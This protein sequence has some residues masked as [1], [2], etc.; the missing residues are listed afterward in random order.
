MSSLQNASLA[1]SPWFLGLIFI[2]ALVL[3]G[4]GTLLWT[5]AVAL[6]G[7]GLFLV[8]APPRKGPGP[9]ADLAVLGILF[10]ILLGFI[11]LTGSFR[12]SWWIE[13]AKSLGIEL[14][15]SVTLQPY[16]SLEALI[17]LLAGLAWLYSAVSWEIGHRMRK[18]LLWAFVISITLLSVGVIAGTLLQM[19][20]PFAKS[21]HNFSYFP[22]RNQTSSLLA[23]GGVVSFGLTM[24]ALLHRRI[25]AIFG[26]V[27][28]GLVFFA[29]IYSLSR[30]GLL[31]FIVGCSIW[32]GLSIRPT[33]M[34]RFSILA[35]SGLVLFFSLFVFFGGSTLS[36]VS[37]L[38]KNSDSSEAVDFRFLVYEDTGRMIAD[39]PVVGVGLANFP[40]AFSQYREASANHNSILHPESDWLWLW[41]ELGLAGF[42]CCIMLLGVLLWGLIPRNDKRGSSTARAA[43]AALFIFL[44]HSIVD[45]GGHR[46]GTIMA[47]IWL[48]GLAR[49]R[50]VSEKPL[51]MA[52]SIWRMFGVLLAGVGVAWLAADALMLPWHSSIVMKRS[53]AM[54][55]PESESLN[56]EEVMETV[57][58]AVRRY[59]L[60]WRAYF[61][62]AQVRLYRLGE[63]AK[64]LED[65]RRARFLEPIAAQVPY[66]EGLAWLPFQPVL[67]ASAW[68]KA[69][70]RQTDD[71]ALIIRG[72]LSNL[73]YSPQVTAL[74]S[75]LS[76]IDPDFRHEYLSRLTGD[77]FLREFSRDLANSPTLGFF[78]CSQKKGILNRWLAIAGPEALIDYLDHQ[79]E[80]AEEQWWFRADILSR[81]RHFLEA[82]EIVWSHLP[83]AAISDFREDEDIESLR[84]TLLSFPSNIVVA[85]SLLKRQIDSADWKGAERTLAIL[86]NQEQSPPFVYYWKSRLEFEKGLYEQSWKSIQIYLK[87]A[88]QPR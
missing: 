65:F 41:A 34:A 61:N 15:T 38:F 59:P 75:D 51:W 42:L 63:P 23:M 9:L 74:V 4:G 36:R 5:Q 44:L 69:L 56:L 18:K 27:C 13:A 84:R 31:L 8:I 16:R 82:L 35:A 28:T 37:N 17:P 22:N 2:T 72:I 77:E 11:P 19:Q 7:I 62:R 26:A 81:Q 10:V 49:Q 14:P 32:V 6:F 40:V 87:S 57:D 76:M 21:V 83:P 55:K 52:P 67:A 25:S 71:R 85:S 47:A 50:P 33:R 78:N 46:F 43:V 79:P 20:Y 53:E 58:M 30:A 29:L 86:E 3:L 68:R 1:R 60:D 54:L 80:L 24:R 12:D 39:E 45:V 88:A 66:Y 48:Y 70:A 73:R 64:A